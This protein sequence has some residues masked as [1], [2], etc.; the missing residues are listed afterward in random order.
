MDADAYDKYPL[1]F[2]KELGVHTN[3]LSYSVRVPFQKVPLLS[4]YEWYTYLKD[5][6]REIVDI[7]Y[8]RGELQTDI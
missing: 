5:V 1:V 3:D 2:T 4:K 7:Y 8:E 6:Q